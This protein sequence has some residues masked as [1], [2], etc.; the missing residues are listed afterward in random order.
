ML[1]R[2]VITRS[3][4]APARQARFNSTVSKITNAGSNAAERVSDIVSKTIYWGKVVGELSKQ[5]YLK[6]KFQIPTISEFQHVYYNIYDQFLR[7]TYRPQQVIQFIQN[8]GKQETI[9]YGSYLVQ[10]LGLFSLGE[11]IGR[12]QI[13]SYPTFHFGDDEEHHH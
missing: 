5:V 9:V 8:F 7:L 13:V 4:R 2:Q 10:I 11:I 3:L 6:E 12:R 1:F